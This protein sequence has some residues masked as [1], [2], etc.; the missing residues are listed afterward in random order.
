MGRFSFLPLLRDTRIS[1]EGVCASSPLDYIVQ[2][3]PRASNGKKNVGSRL[4]RAFD[5]S[6]RCAPGS[7]PEQGGRGTGDT[8][9]L[10]GLYS[11]LL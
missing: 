1:K 6:L 10:A 4:L 5:G 7:K 9:R 3:V 2:G 11:T 8:N